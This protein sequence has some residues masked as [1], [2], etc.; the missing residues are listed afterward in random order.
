VK[1]TQTAL[2]DQNFIRTFY[3]FQASSLLGTQAG[4]NCIDSHIIDGLALSTADFHEGL[5]T[6]T[7]RA[8]TSLQVNKR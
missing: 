4:I 8:G 1:V 5:T 7:S 2:F 3:A 6:Y